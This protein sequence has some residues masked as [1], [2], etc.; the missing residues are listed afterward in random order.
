MAWKN[1]HYVKL[2]ADLHSKSIKHQNNVGFL[3]KKYRLSKV[4]FYKIHIIIRVVVD[5][6]EIIM[7]IVSIKRSITPR[8]NW[9]GVKKNLARL[10]TFYLKIIRCRNEWK[11]LFRKIDGY[12]LN[13]CFKYK[14]VASLFAD[15]SVLYYVQLIKLIAVRIDWFATWFF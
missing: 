15:Y 5:D 13:Y 10:F 3:N 7:K 1:R 4:N 12:L 2:N 11:K 8:K 6:E 14:F 9:E